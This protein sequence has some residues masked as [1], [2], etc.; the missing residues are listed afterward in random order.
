MT[1]R[2]IEI[3]KRVF[4]RYPKT[5]REKTCQ[6]EKNRLESLRELYRR[7]L[8]SEIEQSEISGIVFK[9]DELL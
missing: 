4:E 8:D 9:S 5:N 2:Q 1:Q 7:R 3:N 6:Q